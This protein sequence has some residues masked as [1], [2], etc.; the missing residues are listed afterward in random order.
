MT[1]TALNLIMNAT[2]CTAL[3]NP[4][5]ETEEIRA[6]RDLAPDLSIDATSRKAKQTRFA[7][8]SSIRRDRKARALLANAQWVETV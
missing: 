7:F 4:H 6:V 3:T 2:F 1:T 8:L 5:G